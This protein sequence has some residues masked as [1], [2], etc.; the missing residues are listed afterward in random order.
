[1]GIED[2]K[3][4]IKLSSN[5]YSGCKHCDDKMGDSIEDQIG[6]YVQAH[7]YRLLHVG[8]ESDHAPDGTGLWH[9]TVA[10]LG[11]DNPP[12]QK[13]PA[14]VVIGMPDPFGQR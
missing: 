9:S 5:I 12:P 3:D 14:Q 11:H 10:V 1:M 6:H 7:G 8:Q 13:P 4:V 2:T